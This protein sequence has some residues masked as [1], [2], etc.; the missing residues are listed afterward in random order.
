MVLLCDPEQEIGG[1]EEFV[2]KIK[3]DSKLNYLFFLVSS[4]YTE[5]D[6]DFSKGICKII[7]KNERNSD[8]ENIYKFYNDHLACM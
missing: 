7:S 5:N 8:L 3:N 4:K 1:I 2:E 6:I